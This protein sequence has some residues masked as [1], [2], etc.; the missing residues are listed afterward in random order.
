MGA[1]IN[2]IY[3][4]G[5]GDGW[6][7]PIVSWVAPPS[8]RLSR[9]DRYSR[10]CAPILSSSFSSDRPTPDVASSSRALAPES[11]NQ[12][13]LS[14]FAVFLLFLVL[15]LSSIFP[16]F[17]ASYSTSVFRLC[18]LGGLTCS[19]SFTLVRVRLPRLFWSWESGQTYCSF[20]SLQ[21]ALAFIY[22]FIFVVVV[23]VV[24]RFRSPAPFGAWASRL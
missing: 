11:T 18:R 21:L 17:C 2:S 16:H 10:C 6:Q 7:I 12:S 14:S 3:R 19:D 20:R 4:F 5:L 15:I 1:G 24:L 22:F 13:L 8:S 23:V 9:P